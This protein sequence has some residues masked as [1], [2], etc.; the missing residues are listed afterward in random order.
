MRLTGRIWPV[1]FSG[2]LFA[3]ISHPED[4]VLIQILEHDFIFKISL[5]IPFGK[6]KRQSQYKCSHRKASFQRCQW[7]CLIV[8]RTGSAGWRQIQLCR[9]SVQ[10]LP[11]HWQSK[12]QSEHRVPHSTWF[13]HVCVCVC[14]CMV[15]VN[16]CTAKIP[17]MPKVKSFK[18]VR[19]K[20]EVPC[21][22]WPHLLGLLNVFPEMRCEGITARLFLFLPKPNTSSE[23]TVYFKVSNFIL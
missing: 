5:R 8:P 13:F 16:G 9:V 20:N 23:T 17:T 10:P 15:C 12:W 3:T 4:V 11:C 7:W 2:Q 22:P 18:A 6:S 1:S 21:H 19:M 14:A